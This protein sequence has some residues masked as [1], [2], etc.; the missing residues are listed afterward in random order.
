L[1]DELASRVG[2]KRCRGTDKKWRASALFHEYQCWGYFRK[3][4]TL[5]ERV[6]LMGLR[7]T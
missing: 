6:Y 5:L 2:G 7:K 3:G 1:G 4:K